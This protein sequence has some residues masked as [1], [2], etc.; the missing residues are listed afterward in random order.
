M[1]AYNFCP[2][3]GNELELRER[4]DGRLRPTCTKCGYVHFANPALTVGVLA[5]DAQNRVVLIRRGEEPRQGYWAL[6]AGFMEADESLEEAARRECL[7]ETGLQVSLDELWGVWSYHHADRQTSG[8]LI[9]YRA[10]V[11]GGTPCP[12]TDTTEVRL[13]PADEIPFEQLA[14][15]THRQALQKWCAM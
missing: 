8:I 6:P 11:I 5:T 1:P 2:R 13:C 12:G 10:H 14:F 15:E 3:C 7:E 9:I 4:D